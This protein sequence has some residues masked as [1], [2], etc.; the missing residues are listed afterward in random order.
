MPKN[1]TLVVAALAA[2]SLALAA[3]AALAQMAQQK[4]EKPGNVTRV[5]FTTAKPGAV[6]D[7][8]AGRKRHME[9]HKRMGDTWTWQT[10]VVEVGENVGSYSTVTFNHHWKDY[11]AWEEKNGEADNADVEKNLTPFS[12]AGGNA[13][14][15]YLA[16][17][18]TPASMSPTPLVQLLHFQL[19]GGAEPEFQNAIK[20][21]HEAIQKTKW[22][23]NYQWYSLAV[24]GE[25]LHYVLA[26]PLKGFAEMEDPEVPFPVMLEKALGPVAAKAVMASFDKT[27]AH[28][29]SEILRYRPDLSYNPGAR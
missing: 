27:V 10:Y 4:P 12:V 9:A 6:D 29:W 1:R 24:G 5:F 15:I 19:K 17:S 13:F 11:D 22:A 2:V 23:S 7:Y 26:I 28:Q 18:S 8:E 20:K 16:D 14:Y 3:P 21:T 25:G